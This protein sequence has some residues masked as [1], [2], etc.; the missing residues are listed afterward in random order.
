MGGLI[1]VKPSDVESPGESEAS[2]LGL[3]VAA[4]YAPERPASVVATCVIRGSVPS[5]ASSLSITWSV[6]LCAA[7]AVVS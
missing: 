4:L 7:S 2:V 1:R 5:G 6:P 3:A